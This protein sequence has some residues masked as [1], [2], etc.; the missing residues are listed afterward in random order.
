ME[1]ETKRKITPIH[2]DIFSKFFQQQLK[3]NM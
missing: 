3:Q 1:T 2:H